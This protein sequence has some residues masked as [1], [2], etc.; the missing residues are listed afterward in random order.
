MRASLSTEAWP[1]LQESA[2]T[3]CKSATVH[4]VFSLRSHY[5]VEPR[6]RL[7]GLRVVELHLSIGV[8][9]H[10]S[11][12][13]PIAEVRGGLDLVSIVGPNQEFQA[14]SATRKI[15]GLFDKRANC[16][17]PGIAIMDNR[18]GVGASSYIFL[19]AL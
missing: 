6:R 5:A 15:R 2:A 11:N 8:T 7:C 17:A 16:M 13:Y 3:L 18:H 10:C 1:H 14:D 12:R 9:S 4:F 19:R